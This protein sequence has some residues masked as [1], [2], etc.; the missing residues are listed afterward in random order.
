[1]KTPIKVKSGNSSANFFQIF[2]YLLQI[3]HSEFIQIKIFPFGLS[4]IDFGIR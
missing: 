4:V 2:G 1:V 3:G